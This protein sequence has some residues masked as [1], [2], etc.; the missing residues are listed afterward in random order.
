MGIDE[1]LKERGNRYGEFKDHAEISQ[2]LKDVMRNF[3]GWN[4]LSDDKKEALEMIQHKIARI[5]NGDPSYADSWHDITGYA[6]LVE[7][8]LENE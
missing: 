7:A 4:R 8:Q 2:S 3:P 5:L 6:R 1:T